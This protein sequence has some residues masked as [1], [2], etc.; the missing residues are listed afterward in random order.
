[1]LF[2]SSRMTIGGNFATYTF[3]C[4]IHCS[5]KCFA[6]VWLWALAGI[7]TW[8]QFEIHL[9]LCTQYCKM[10]LGPAVIHAVSGCDTIPSLSGIGKKTA[11]II[12]TTKNQSSNVYISKWNTR[13]R[14]GWVERYAVLIRF[15]ASSLIKQ[16]YIHFC[17][18]CLYMQ[19]QPTWEHLHTCLACQGL[20]SERHA[21][22][23]PFFWLMLGERRGHRSLI[24]SCMGLTSR[25]IQT[26]SGN[27]EM[28]V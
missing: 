22:K 15:K 27:G 13:Q 10:V 9:Y 23:F 8:I 20:S 2:I 1:M 11:E 6:W 21:S 19:K 3:P 5:I 14:Y 25:S 4:I 26:M 28:Q 16:E 17:N 24:E 12:A 18:V 7:W